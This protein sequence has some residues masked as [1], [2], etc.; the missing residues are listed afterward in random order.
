[1][2]HPCDACIYSPAL[3]LALNARTAVHIDGVLDDM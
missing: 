2:F 3:A 1:M